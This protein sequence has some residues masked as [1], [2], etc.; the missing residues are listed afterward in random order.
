MSIRLSILGRRVMVIRSMPHMHDVI[1]M[2][3]RT[4]TKTIVRM[5]YV[6]LHLSAKEPLIFSGLSCFPSWT[7]SQHTM[8]V[9]D[10]REIPMV[11][12]SSSSTMRVSASSCIVKLLNEDIH[13]D[14]VP[15]LSYEI[16]Y[17]VRYSPLTFVIES[18]IISSLADSSLYSK[19]Y[20]S[21]MCIARESERGL[22]MASLVW[23]TS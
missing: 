23:I 11:H 4:R 7:S 13:S 20:S 14:R 9:A 3:T 15:H 16:L 10:T 18:Y 8:T 6:S 5:P 21:M 19:A 22:T 12:S 1:V 17:S 2:A